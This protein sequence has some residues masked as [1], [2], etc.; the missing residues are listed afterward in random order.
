M[1]KSLASDLNITLIRIHVC[2]LPQKFEA[3]QREFESKSTAPLD[4][5]F[6]DLAAASTF[7]H[8]N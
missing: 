7:N 6:S 5:E 4:G 8:L 3:L 1:T 2:D